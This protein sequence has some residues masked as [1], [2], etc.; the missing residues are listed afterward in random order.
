MDKTERLVE[1]TVAVLTS[2]L[3]QII[4]SRGGIVQDIKSLSTAEQVTGSGQ[5]VLEEFVPIVPLKRFQEDE[6]RR[7]QSPSSIEI[8][9]EVRSQLRNYLFIVA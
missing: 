6:L 3:Q 8:G 5:T 1:W 7:R 4:A 2:L 9:E